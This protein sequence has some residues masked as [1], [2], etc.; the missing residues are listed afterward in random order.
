M[1]PIL[2]R[3]RLIGASGALGFGLALPDWLLAASSQTS[4][5]AMPETST[6]QETV[7]QA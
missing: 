4:D 7:R 1:N 5:P 6:D 3:R 2:T